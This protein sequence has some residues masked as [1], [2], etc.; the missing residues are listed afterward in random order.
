MQIRRS[1]GG[2]DSAWELLVKP[3]VSLRRTVL[4]L[5]SLRGVIDRI[6]VLWLA[7]VEMF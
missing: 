4:V 1:R 6:P 7:R 2:S 5:L 3:I